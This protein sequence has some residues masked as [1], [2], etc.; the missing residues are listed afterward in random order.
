VAHGTPRVPTR[1]LS[2]IM[3]CMMQQAM[4]NVNR[5]AVSV[6]KSKFS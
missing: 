5:N 6:T 4:Q 2:A 3:I 1:H